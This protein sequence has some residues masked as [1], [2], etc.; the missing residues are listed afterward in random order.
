VPLDVLLGDAQARGLAYQVEGRTFLQLH[1]FD[2]DFTLFWP[3]EPGRMSP[4]DLVG[5]FDIALTNR[6]TPGPPIEQVR[7]E[8]LLER[9]NDEWTPDTMEVPT[10]PSYG[11]WDYRV[12]L[13]FFG[14]R[15]DRSVS[16]TLT[17]SRV[18]STLSSTLWTDTDL[19]PGPTRET[20]VTAT[21]GSVLVAG[22]A[23]L[24]R[25]TLHRSVGDAADSVETILSSELPSRTRS[26]ERG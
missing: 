1:E 14:G 3:S 26:P 4:G 16:F 7:G 9:G 22:L 6:R 5:T 24:M 8:A 13:E 23:R 25:T 17:A 2:D 19:T 10:D 15:W 11:G 21:Y 20:G 12:L 18:S